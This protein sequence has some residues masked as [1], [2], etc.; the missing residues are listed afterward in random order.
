MEFS[1]ER[2][3]WLLRMNHVILP[4]VLT[5]F[6]ALALVILM[7]GRQAALQ[8][9]GIALGAAVIVGAIGAWQHRPA[10]AP[11]K[12]ADKETAE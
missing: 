3:K 10:K 5:F 6:I 12:P 7:N 4:A 1:P 9:P 8:A 11:Q 2:K